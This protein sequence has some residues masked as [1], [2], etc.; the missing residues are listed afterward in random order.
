MQAADAVCTF[1][2]LISDPE[3]RYEVIER[4]EGALQTIKKLPH[5]KP[6]C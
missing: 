1:S 4:V 5:E 6:Q 2:R 3:S